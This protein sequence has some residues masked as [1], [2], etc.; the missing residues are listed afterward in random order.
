MAVIHNG[1]EE[2]K[3]EESTVQYYVR[4]DIHIDVHIFHRPA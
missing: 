1:G 4:D 2:K 3:K